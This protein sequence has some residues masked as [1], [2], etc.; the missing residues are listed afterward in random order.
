MIKF[1]EQ[2]LAEY[3]V[4]CL[5]SGGNGVSNRDLHFLVVF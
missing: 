1:V 2:M 5:R 4:E 3:F